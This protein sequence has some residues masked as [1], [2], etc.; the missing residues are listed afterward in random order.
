[1]KDFHG[2]LQVDAYSGYDELFRDRNRDIPEVALGA[3]AS[4]HYFEAQFSDLMHLTVILAH[5][6][7]PYNVA[8]EART[9]GLTGEARKALRQAKSIPILEDIGVR[10]PA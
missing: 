10:Y 7:L 6:R 3:P 9:M 8:R 2:Y 1:M 4:R 5:I